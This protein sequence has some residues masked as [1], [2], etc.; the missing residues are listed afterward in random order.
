MDGWSGGGSFLYSTKISSAVRGM[1]LVM[2]KETTVYWAAAAEDGEFQRSAQSAEQTAYLVAPGRVTDLRVASIVSTGLGASTMTVTLQWTAPGDN[3]YS[4]ALAGGTF[5]IRY[6]TRAPILGWNDYSTAPFTVSITTSVNAGELQ[7]YIFS[8]LDVRT[9]HYFAIT[10]KDSLGVRSA[11][12]NLNAIA[13]GYILLLPGT[14]GSDPG[15]AWGDYDRD[16]DLDLLLSDSRLMRNDGNGSFA[17]VAVP[18]MGG[19]GAAW[20]DYD[21]DGDLD[22]VSNA[23][24]IGDEVV[25]RNDGGA[26]TAVAVTGSAGNSA[27][28]NAWGDVDN[29]GRLDFAAANQSAENEVLA[30]NNGNGTFSTSTLTGSGGSSQGIAWGDYDNDGDLDLAVANSGEDPVL[31]RND[32]GGALSVTTALNGFGFPVR[33]LAWGDYDKDGDLDLALARSG[34]ADES[35]L[36]NNG[37][38]TF[39]EAVLTGSGGDSYGVAW[40]DYDNDG[41]LD[42]AAANASGQDEAVLRNNGNGTFSKFILAGTAGN[43]HGISWGDFDG[44]GDLDLAAA[45][46][47]KQVMAL[48]NDAA[49][50][51]SYPTPPA[52]GFSASYQEYDASASSGVLTLQWGGG[53]DVED[54]TA[55]LRYFVRVGTTVAGSSTTLK[56]PSGFSTDGFAGG[57]SFLY[58]TKIS[59][60][61]RGLRL[62]MQKETTVYWSVVT[63]DSE[64]LRSS[65]STEQTSYLVAPGRVTDLRVS[66]VSSTGLGASS[67]TVTLQWTAPGDNGYSGALAGGSYDIRYSTLAPITAAGAYLAAPFTLSISTNAN[68]GEN[69]TALIQYL[70]AKATHYFAITAKDSTGIRSLLSNPATAEAYVRYPTA[71]GGNSKAVAWGDYDKDG[72][73]DALVANGGGA[74]EFLMRNDG[75]GAFTQVTIAGSGGDSTAVAWGDYDNDGDLDALVANTGSEDEFLLRND[76]GTFTKVVLTGTAGNSKAV[77][78][79]DYDN[80]GDLDAIVANAGTQGEYLLRNNGTSFS[81]AAIIGTGGD[82]NSAAW[83]DHD[84]DGDLDAIVANGGAEDE[85]LLRNDGSGVF[86]PLVIAGGSGGASYGAAWGD[87][88]NDGDPDVLVANGGTEDEVLLRND[89][90]GT[91]S[92]VTLTGSGGDTRGVVWGDA[93]NDG[94]LDALLASGGGEDKI[95]LRNEGAGTFA[96]IVLAGSKAESR[97]ASWGDYD[98]DADLDAVLA[99]DSAQD[100]LIL[101][102]DLASSHNAPLAPSSGFTASFQEY[103]V[104]ATSGVLTLSW[105][106]GSDAETSAASLGYLVRIGTTVAGSSTTLKVP[107]RVSLNGS[108]PYS[109]R[110]TPAARGLKIVM[111]KETTAYWAVTAEDGESLRSS[112]SAEQSAFLTAPAAIADLAAAQDNTVETSSSAWMTLT[113]TVPGENGSA[114]TLQPGSVY[115]LRWSTAG[116]VDSQAKYEA[117]PNQLLIA[118]DGQVPGTVRTQLVAMP[119]GKTYYFALTTKDS[120][121]SR[122]GLSNAAAGVFANA[123]MEETTGIAIPTALQGDTT[124]FLKVKLWVDSGMP[125]LT[126]LKI[127]V[128]KT[129]GLPDSAVKN[130]AVYQDSNANGIFDAADSFALRTSPAVFVSSAATLT[131]S[132]SQTINTTT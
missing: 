109:T 78:W 9:S 45:S 49:L 128:R 110:I 132:P 68:P 36:R 107:A 130:V 52:A 122:S 46:D 37:N 108:F 26:F 76:G 1:K 73:L 84:G 106:N 33:A 40:G 112:E 63:E 18:G 35:L 87:Y 11:L 126:W 86:V 117:V 47:D 7:T 6:S 57:G 42:L 59:S 60:A 28:G 65:S 22:I 10:T 77:A 74:D 85:V 23:N 69:Q 67:M 75:N 121:G 123:L 70:E 102:N 38:G 55:T 80:D 120:F 71:T 5:D 20:G 8:N 24:A 2:Q 116:A 89:G 17:Q 27:G 113:W 88:D 34:G 21:N 16:G 104:F 4:G 58:S 48:R 93:D 32:G 131:L 50:A 115:D 31:L 43:T 124:A 79:G 56:L 25:L 44:D 90:G 14:S 51:H 82:S 129:G 119:P 97:G 118:A 83:G 13:T 66:V 62:V 101:R 99:G 61:A 127:G 125:S 94:D 103:G 19:F 72:D 3:G 39:T 111:Q 98:G 95:L 41:D 114:S 15:A 105:G 29:D 12:S 91:F 54:S 53:S 64:F 81:S 96:K 100:E 92:N 30:R